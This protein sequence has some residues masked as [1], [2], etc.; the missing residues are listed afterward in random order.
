MM[1]LPQPIISVE[2][3][4]HHYRCACGIA[5]TILSDYQSAVK[6]DCPICRQTMEPESKACPERH[7]HE[8]AF[9]CAG[10]GVR[11]QE[12]NVT[13]SVIIQVGERYR[14]PMCG[15]FQPDAEETEV[16]SPGV[17]GEET[18]R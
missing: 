17:R 9:Q 7:D 14:C 2:Q 4:R 10:C 8:K 3:Y 5:F 16:S 6:M 15:D 1:E 18:S 13:K 11:I 12:E